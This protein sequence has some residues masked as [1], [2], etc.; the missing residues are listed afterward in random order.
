MYAPE[1]P[2]KNNTRFHT[3]MGKVFSDQKGPKPLPFHYIMTMPML[4]L[5]G[6]LYSPMYIDFIQIIQNPNT[7]CTLV[8]TSSYIREYHPRS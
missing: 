3:K 2:S 6:V 4:Y 7:K 8:D 5:F 1:V